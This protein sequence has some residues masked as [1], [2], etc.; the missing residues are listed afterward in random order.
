M[1]LLAL[2]V[3][4]DVLRP[5]VGAV[6]AVEIESIPLALVPL[7]FLAVVLRGGFARV[8]QLTGLVSALTQSSGSRRDL[9]DALGRALGD[10]SAQLLQWD[11]EQDGYVDTDGRPAP[12]PETAGDRAS[13]TISS[14]GDRLGAIVY[15]PQLTEDPRAV[16]PVARVAAIAL[17]RER[18][19]QEAAESREA[20]RVASSRLLEEADR[21]RRRIA[22]DLHDGLQG[23]LVRLSLSAHQLA[24]DGAPGHGAAAQLAADIDRAAADLRDLVQGVMP[25]PLVERGLPAALQD[26]VYS[27]PV[28][29]RLVADLPGRL[30]APV[31]STAYF[32]VAEALTNVVKHARARGVEVD[33]RVVDSGVL[34]INVRDDGRGGATA[35]PAGAGLTGLRDRIEVLGGRLRVDSGAGGTH[36]TAELPCAW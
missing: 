3:G 28:R 9:Q 16:E 31:E 13:T 17:D 22:Q 29:A 25:A 15:D 27:L 33:L 6:R 7:G 2:P 14:A 11:P 30:P 32:V 5:R 34:R 24:A 12:P 20:L 35:T 36:L 21:E 8:G 18:L 26:L 19:A 4:G 23:S 10:P 1:A